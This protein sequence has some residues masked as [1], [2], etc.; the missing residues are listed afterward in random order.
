MGGEGTTRERAAKQK[1]SI[2]LPRRPDWSLLRGFSLLMQRNAYQIAW[3]TVCCAR[4]T[5]AQIIK[6]NFKNGSL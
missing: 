3:E 6:G 5:S 4:H 2:M 1:L